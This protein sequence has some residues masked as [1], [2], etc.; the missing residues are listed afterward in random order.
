MVVVGLV[1]VQ[2]HFEPNNLGIHLLK[3]S[4]LKKDLFSISLQVPTRES[5]IRQAN[6][7]INAKQ[8]R[9]AHS[10]QIAIN[11]GKYKMGMMVVVCLPVLTNTVAGG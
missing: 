6:L 3:K 2:S 1:G 4:N 8:V 5:I 10:C 11:S 7:M 9:A